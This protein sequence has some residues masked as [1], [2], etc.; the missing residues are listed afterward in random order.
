MKPAPY[1][2]TQQYLRADWIDSML[3]KILKFSKENAEIY[4]Y[5]GD[6]ELTIDSLN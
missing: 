4:I 2:Y 6:N 3:R 5:L 1:A